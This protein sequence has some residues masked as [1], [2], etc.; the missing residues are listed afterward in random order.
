MYAFSFSN[1][2][3]RKATFYPMSSIHTKE[4]IFHETSIERKGK[5]REKSS[6]PGTRKNYYK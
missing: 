3:E 5:S 2:Q 1:A 4:K 6:I